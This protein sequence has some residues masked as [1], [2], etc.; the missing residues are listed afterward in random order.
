VW[1]GEGSPQIKKNIS[2]QVLYNLF[3]RVDQC[4]LVAR[5]ITI[6]LIVL[7]GRLGNIGVDAN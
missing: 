7:R 1:G 4:I 5:L 3:I 2:Y 6:I